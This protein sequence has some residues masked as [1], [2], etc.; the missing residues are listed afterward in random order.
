MPVDAKFV[1]RHVNSRAPKP[2]SSIGKG[3]IG[4]GVGLVGSTVAQDG[5]NEI[6][7]A[8]KREIATLVSR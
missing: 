4:T 6:E 1:T 3:L 2:L 8:F 7:K 5:I